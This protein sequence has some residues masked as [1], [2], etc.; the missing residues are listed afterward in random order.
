MK[1]SMK[2]I[3]KEKNSRNH[4]VKAILSPSNVIKLVQQQ[5]QQEKLAAIGAS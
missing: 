5:Q 2:M 1:Y 3:H 4:I